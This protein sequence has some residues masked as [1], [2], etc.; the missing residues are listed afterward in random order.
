VAFRLTA[1]SALRPSDALKKLV[2]A[3]AIECWCIHP[4]TYLLAMTCATFNHSYL[5]WVSTAVEWTVFLGRPQM[6]LFGS[7]KEVSEPDQ[8]ACVDPTHSPHSFD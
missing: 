4:D 8:M 3:S 7:S 2:G 1:S 6:P 5:T